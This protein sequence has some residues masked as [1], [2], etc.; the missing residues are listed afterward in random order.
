LARWTNDL[1]TSTL[2]RALHVGESPRISGA[3]FVYPNDQ[4]IVSCLD[5]CQAADNPRRYEPVVA[6]D[7][8]R[9]LREDAQRAGRPAVARDTAERLNSTS[10]APR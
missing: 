6:E 4:A 5:T 8:V 2:H 3:F 7:Y 9:I 1:Y 10:S